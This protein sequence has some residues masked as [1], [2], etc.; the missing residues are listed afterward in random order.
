MS[1]YCNIIGLTISYIYKRQF[2][3]DVPD[4]PLYERWTS[5]CTNRSLDIP[6]YE[7]LSKD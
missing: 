3:Q 1:L 7:P 2:G 4:I 5:H 6:Q